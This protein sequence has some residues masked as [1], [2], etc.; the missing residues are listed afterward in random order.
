MEVSFLKLLENLIQSAI[1][2]GPGMVIA[3]IILYGLYK[4]FKEVGLKIADSAK[5]M[6][7]SVNRQTDSMKRLGDTIENYVSRDQHEHQEIIILQ[8][9]I[10]QELRAIR[11]QSER[12]EERMG[13]GDHGRSQVGNS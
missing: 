2:H 6:A 12:I 4:L 5:Q 11:E 9:V 7:D 10:R 13:G 1:D 3:V 8:K